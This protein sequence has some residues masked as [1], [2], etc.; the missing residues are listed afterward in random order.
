MI[1]RRQTA[2]NPMKVKG[3]SWRHRERYMR[4][5]KHL[6]GDLGNVAKFLPWRRNKG[7]VDH[8]DQMD[9]GSRGGGQENE[10]YRE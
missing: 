4:L 7:V 3:F 10:I 1:L 2:E 8:G 6:T 9:H 5:H